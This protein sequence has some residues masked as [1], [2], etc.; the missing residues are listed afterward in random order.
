MMVLL[1]APTIV[2]PPVPPVTKVG[3]LVV[4]SPA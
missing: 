1:A 2:L 4:A 3:V